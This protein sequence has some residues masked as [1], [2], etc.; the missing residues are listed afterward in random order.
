ME[1]ND[2]SG[3]FALKGAVVLVAFAIVLSAALSIFHVYHVIGAVREKTDE[4]VLAAAA[5]NVAEFYGGAR[6]SDGFARHPEDG[7]FACNLSADDVADNLAQSLGATDRT[8]D[9]R[10][11]VGDSYVVSSLNPQ[12]VNYDGTNLHFDTTLTVTVPLSAGGLAL[13]DITK[14]IE[15]KSSYD[16]RF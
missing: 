4:A 16:P 3:E 11:T 10:I 7:R 13:S 5:N 9:N 14:T 8:E 1:M 15:V 6:E 12:Y 2:T